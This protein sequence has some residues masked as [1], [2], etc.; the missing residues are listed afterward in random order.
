MTPM[1]A[2]QPVATGLLQLFAQDRLVHIDLKAALLVPG[3]PLDGGLL[4][5]GRELHDLTPTERGLLGDHVHDLVRRDGLDQQILGRLK[6]HL[7]ASM[8]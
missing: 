8:G 4:Q 5:C 3:E 7:G 1:M 2:S 6:A